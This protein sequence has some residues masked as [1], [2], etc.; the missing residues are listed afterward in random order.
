MK[1]FARLMATGQVPRVA[2]NLDADGDD[3][4]P[5]SNHESEQDG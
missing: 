4:D 5:E 1:W 2:A 3:M